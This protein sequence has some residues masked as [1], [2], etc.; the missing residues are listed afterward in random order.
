MSK[1]LFE[2]DLPIKP[3]NVSMEMIKDQL[4]DPIV[5]LLIEEFSKIISHGKAQNYRTAKAY[6]ESDVTLKCFENIDKA[7]TKRFGMK[8]KHVSTEYSL[9]AVLTNSIRNNS[10]NKDFED[11]FEEIKKEVKVILSK[12]NEN[13]LKSTDEINS[14]KDYSDIMYRYKKSI[15]SLIS[16]AGMDGVTIDLENAKIIGLPN[17]FVN[18]LFISPNLLI[19]YLGLTAEEI[20]ACLL[21]EVGHAYTHIEYS[22]R[23]LQTVSVLIDTINAN[24]GKK[25]DIFKIIY[26]DALKKDPKDLNGNQQAVIYRVIEESFKS[27]L[28]IN[29]NDTSNSDSEHLADQFSSKFGMGLHLTTGLNKMHKSGY[30]LN[31]ITIG[32]AISTIISLAAFFLF[33]KY[34]ISISIVL[35]LLIITIFYMIILAISIIVI[36]ILNIIFNDNKGKVNTGTYDSDI[37]RIERLKNNV[38]RQLRTLDLPKDQM[39]SLISNVEMIKITIDQL[40][41]IYPKD[42]IGIVDKMYRFLSKN[43]QNKLAMKD[44]AMFIEDMM[45]NELHL[46]AAKF[47][48]I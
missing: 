3:I 12:K 5:S 14:D 13:D 41:S 28:S 15:D 8:F 34:I 37:R 40:A 38:I 39:K 6:F 32:S 1:K 18:F 35:E 19:N 31:N 25:K 11:N 23:S 29:N 2:I 9:Y 30:E 26:T 44:Y 33:L 27:I 22:A 20:T 24:R 43:V 42:D 45:E 46:S 48:T 7:L 36:F 4:N 16:K 17:D 10:I 21:H 47:K